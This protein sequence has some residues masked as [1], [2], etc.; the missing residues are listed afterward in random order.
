L[1]DR[2]GI[3]REGEKV[4]RADEKELRPLIGK[5]QLVFPSNMTKYFIICLVSTTQQ[6]LLFKPLHLKK[7]TT[8]LRM[9]HI[10]KISLFVK[11]P[12]IF[13]V[14]LK[15]MSRQNVPICSY[16]LSRLDIHENNKFKLF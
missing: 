11:H 10:H 14:V 13:S 3:L 15:N 16:I 4:G 1:S 2:V 5:V 9:K 6:R 8:Y 7:G 12:Y